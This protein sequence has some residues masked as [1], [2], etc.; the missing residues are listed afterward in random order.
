MRTLL[1]FG[2]EA[3]TANESNGATPFI[4]AVANRQ[5]DPDAADEIVQELLEHQLNSARMPDYE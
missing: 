2:A 4:E 1:E 5:D 3:E